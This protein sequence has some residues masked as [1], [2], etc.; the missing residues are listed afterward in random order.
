MPIVHLDFETRS[1]LSV[2]AVG[3]WCYSRHPSTSILCAAFAVD[4][5]VVQLLERGSFEYFS[6]MGGAQHEDLWA[7]AYEPTTTFYAHNSFFEQ[8]IW[9][10]IMVP[11]YGF[12]EIPIERWRCTA[13]KAASMSLPRDL[14][15]VG[16]ALDLPIQKDK[17]GH[18]VMMKLSR[19]RRNKGGE[20][21]FWEYD[22]CP[23]D[24]EK[25]YR[26]CM[27]DVETERLVDKA[28]PSLNAR[29]QKVWFLDQKINFRGVRA[30]VAAIQQTLKFIDTTV[31]ELTTE[32]QQITDLD[33]PS[34]VAK[35]RSWLEGEGVELPN[36]Q[37][38]TVDKALAT[39]LHT[40]DL[41]KLYRNSLHGQVLAEAGISLPTTGPMS[42]N[43]RRALE[44]RRQLSKISTAKYEAMLNRADMEDGRIRDI[45]LYYAAL[46][47]RWG[48]RGIQPQNLPRGTVDSDVAISFIQSDD[49]HWFTGA[50]PDPMSAYSSCIRGMLTASPG[51]ELYVADFASIEAR[52]LPWL[53]G[54]ESALEVFRNNGDPYCEEATGIFGRPITKK[55]KYERSVGKVSVLALG[56]GGGIGAFGAMARAYS[57]DLRP[58]YSILWSSATTDE[59]EKARSAYEFY[60]KRQEREENPDP[61]DM[62]SGYASDIVKQRWR[63]KNDKVVQFWADL[64]YAA[65]EAVLTGQKQTVGGQV[66]IGAPQYW[67][68]GDE[69]LIEEL[70]RRPLITYGM[71]GE[72]LLCKLPSGNCLVYPFAKVSVQET[73]WGARK[74]AL[75]YKTQ[76]EKNYQYG[77]TFTYGGKLAEN[78]TQAV[79]R[80]LLADALLRLDAAGFDIVLH[81]H[82]EVVAE[83]PEGAGRLVEYERVMS[84]VPTWAAGLPVAA[85]AWK[86]YRYRK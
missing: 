11:R 15:G 76:N 74:S 41:A 59:Q 55:D 9:R 57:M 58:A 64:E 80:D 26:Y 45:L 35:F 34:Q 75:T 33:S 81:V 70:Q 73:D 21:L 40:I 20:L 63:R 79:A 62:A 85:E 53:A 17:E 29:E 16:M 31:S 67:Q 13:A 32:F 60:L 61:L 18:R 5:E 19:P 8:C 43:A 4:D 51:N 1:Q 37:A 84:E 46:T 86:G 69:I 36:L 39:E 54:Q 71:M 48:G 28:L 56:Y 68:P 78:V 12:P 49:Y 38:A 25:L 7:A 3:G 44:I 42:S 30:D 6:V 23:E 14:E 10:N 77:R 50:Y 22:D 72:H 82:D 2:K 24:F 47:G 83:S 66:L 52:V 27:T 65:V